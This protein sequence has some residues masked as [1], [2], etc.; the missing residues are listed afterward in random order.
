M[1]K[2]SYIKAFFVCLAE[3]CKRVSTGCF[4]LLGLF[5][6]SSSEHLYADPS[7]RMSDAVRQAVLE[8]PE[9][10]LEWQRLRAALQANKA[11]R[12][13][14]LPEVNFSADLGQ[15][16]RS[17]PQTDFDPYNRSTATLTI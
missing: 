17:T 9:V 11:S 4:F 7:M 1:N 5:I 13:A 15:E 12:G 8:N 10:N 2:F 14:L 16:Q 6:A 3:P